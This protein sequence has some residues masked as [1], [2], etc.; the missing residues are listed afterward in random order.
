LCHFYRKRTLESIVLDFSETEPTD[1]SHINLFHDDVSNLKKSLS[2]TKSS[3]SLQFQQST[4][5]SI[6]E[7]IRQ[8]M[9]LFND[10]VD[11]KGKQFS[12]A[13]PVTTSPSLD[14]R[15]YGKARSPKQR[16]LQSK[17]TLI[18][19]HTFLKIC[20][21]IIEECLKRKFSVSDIGIIRQLI[22]QHDP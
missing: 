21:K 13:S 17:S 9:I 20:W 3:L 1:F 10:S 12:D 22:F 11:S 16:S 8:Q 6:P 5:V 4:S 15:Y 18:S 7:Q 2:P 19:F 14:S